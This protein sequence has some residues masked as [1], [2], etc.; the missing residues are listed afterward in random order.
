MESGSQRQTRNLS[1]ASSTDE[2]DS[3]ASALATKKRATVE[4]KYSFEEA[5][6]AVKEAADL[7]RRSPPLSDA[8]AVPQSVCT[9]AIILNPSDREDDQMDDDSSSELVSMPGFLRCACRRVC[10]SVCPRTALRM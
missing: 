7:L 9:G 2:A 10:K 8:V 4:K 3:S 6:K 1:E 5:K